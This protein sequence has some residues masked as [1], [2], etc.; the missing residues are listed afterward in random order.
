[1][2]KI[3]PLIVVGILTAVIGTGA[4]ATLVQK[5]GA[6]AEAAGTT[7]ALVATAAVTPG[8]PVAQAALEVREVPGNLVPAG[9][10]TDVTALANQV[11]LRP[12]AP[13]EVVA[14][15]AFG[16][17]G[18]AAA[19][20]VILPVGKEGIGVELA[21]VPGGLRYVVPGNKVT[22]WATPKV[23]EKVEPSAKV[24]L[25]NIQVI[26]T[27]PGAGTGAATE[28]VA[29]PGTL[30]FLLALSRDESAQLIAE[31]ARGSALYFT[32]SNSGQAAR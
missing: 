18:V 32:L 12:L 15:G 30:Q 25:Q 21:F 19:G 1:M 13:G 3:N 4:L 8:T 6:T 26:A 31:Q 11:A 28:V 17:Q 9:S 23:A 29:G 20:G 2:K 27:T 10:A 22:V 16:V 24:L 7:R 14:P 5:D